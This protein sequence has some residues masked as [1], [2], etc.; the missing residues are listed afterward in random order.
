MLHSDSEGRL[1]GMDCSRNRLQ[2]AI[3]TIICSG[4]VFVSWYS[5]ELELSSIFPSSENLD[6]VANEMELP[7][8]LKAYLSRADVQAGS[9]PRRW[10]KL[11]HLGNAVR[12]VH[13]THHLNSKSHDSARIDCDAVFSYYC[14]QIH[15]Y[16]ALCAGRSANC[17]FALEK[18]FSEDLCWRVVQS[19]NLPAQVRGVFISLLEH[20]HLD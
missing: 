9:V 20:L 17:S 7:S 15:F 14:A 13:S 6:I 19:P 12:G 5:G 18:Q 8:S 10:I 16:A 3:E 11:E 4:E 2:L 1:D